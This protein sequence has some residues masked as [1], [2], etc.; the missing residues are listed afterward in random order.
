MYRTEIPKVINQ[1]LAVFY[2]IGIWDV[3]ERTKF[4]RIGLKLFHFIYYIT[5]VIS[6]I[7]GA[8]LT[9]DSDEFVFLSGVSFGVCLHIVRMFYIISRKEKILNFIQAIGLHTTNEVVEFVEINRKLKKLT[10]FATYFVSGCIVDLIF[11]TI[12]PVL[13][14][15]K[16]IVNIAFPQSFPWENGPSTYWIK[17]LFIVIGCIYPIILILLTIIVMYLM[18]NYAIKYEML[19]NQLKVLGVKNTSSKK[20]EKMKVCKEELFVKCLIDA[21]QNHREINEYHQH[22][23]H[24]IIN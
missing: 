24:Q 18:L 2:K 22:Y 15:K 13:S 11:L 8:F 14:G 5:F 20:T 12:F 19:G 21:I 4:S 7:M 10:K 16:M 6:I 1:I 9:T 17:H 23:N 3:P